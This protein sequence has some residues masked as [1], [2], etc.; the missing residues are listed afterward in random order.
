MAYFD[1]S[2][3]DNSEAGAD[4]EG[5]SGDLSQYD[6]HDFTCENLLQAMIQGDG[7]PAPDGSAPHMPASVAALH[8][9]C[10]QNPPETKLTDSTRICDL[11]GGR[12]TKEF[13]N[14]KWDGEGFHLLE[15]RYY[16]CDPES[17]LIYFKFPYTEKKQFACT[18]NVR[19]FI[20]N[21]LTFNR[22]LRR[23]YDYPRPILVYGSYEMAGDL[24]VSVDSENQIARM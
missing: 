5:V 21:P 23:L 8:A 2:K 14:D 4:Y 12:E 10:T 9:V 1:F 15:L 18:F 24:M 7:A 13:Y 17:D 22:V 3:I 19:L 11:Y 16:D 20:N 6:F